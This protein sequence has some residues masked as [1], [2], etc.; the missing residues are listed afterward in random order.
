[1]YNTDSSIATIDESGLEALC[2]R[3]PPTD[4]VLGVT[5]LPKLKRLLRPP[6]SEP[7]D[8]LLADVAIRVQLSRTDY[9][10]AEQRY[11]T[12]GDW[13]DRESSPLHGR[14]QLVYPQ[15]SMAI[16]ATTASQ[17]TTD[18]FDVD[19][20]AQLGLPRGTPPRTVLD[21]L[22]A[23]IRGEP[24][25]LYYDMAER[26]TRCVT[27]HYADNMHADITPMI[28]LVERAERVSYLFHSKPEDVRDPDLTLIANPHGFAEWFKA[29]TP[30]DHDFAAVFAKRAQEYERMR[31]AAKADSEELP[32]QEPAYLKSKAVI[33]LQ[34]MKRFRNV[35]Y[36]RRTTRRPPSIMMAK[37]IADAANSTESLSDEL[38]HQAR[39][40]HGTLQRWQNAGLLI[41]VDNPTCPEDVLTDRWPGSLRE[42]GEFIADLEYLIAKV[43]RLVAG[44]PLQ[45]MRAIMAD[46]FGEAPAEQAFRAFNERLGS[47]IQGGRSQYV[48]DK[49]RLVLPT[50]AAVSSVAAPSIAR[51]TPRHT[52]FGTERRKK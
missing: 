3:R 43:E 27:V 20:I 19:F 49:G 4:E 52:F 51:A 44:C 8:V 29:S 36:D 6:L 22:F 39:A 30:L 17:L 21:L 46:L 10:K 40:M 12:L 7:V 18:E 1:M 47:D 24:G 33:V 28:R 35:R 5:N 34:L 50:A 26:R 2:L 31:L 42:Q 38:L 37:L 45:E 32:D 9:N 11:Q 48:P 41:V 23:S 14:V 16:G 13:I 15:G 25:S